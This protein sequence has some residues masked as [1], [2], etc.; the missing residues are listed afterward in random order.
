MVLSQDI[1]LA[2]VTKFVK[3]SYNYFNFIELYAKK[4]N[5]LRHISAKKEEIQPLVFEKKIFFLIWY[6]VAIATRGKLQTFNISVFPLCTA[7][8]VWMESGQWF[9]RRC[10]LKM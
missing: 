1:A 5:P 2:M 3:V 4:D 8:K 6:L 9:Q 10:S 7:D